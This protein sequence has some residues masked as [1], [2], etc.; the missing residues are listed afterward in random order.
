MIAAQITYA[1]GIFAL[2]LIIGMVIEALRN[3]LD[4]RDSSSSTTDGSDAALMSYLESTGC[5]LL[6]N[7]SVPGWALLD[8]QDKMIATAHS[9]RTT[10]A[11][12]MV[13]DKAIASGAGEHHRG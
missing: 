9:V 8:G 12:A 10:L 6:F 4:A 3:R 13:K 7:S 2:G 5:N 11:R 1:I